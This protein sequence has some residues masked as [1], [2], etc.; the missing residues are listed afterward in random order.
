MFEHNITIRTYWLYST[1]RDTLIHI[2][3]C[4]PVVAMVTTDL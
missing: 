1:C 3:T 4:T 2:A